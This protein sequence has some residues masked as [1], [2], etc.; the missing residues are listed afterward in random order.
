[1]V[2]V[3]RGATFG[4][5]LIGR[6]S[7]ID[8][9]GGGLEVRNVDAFLNVLRV[10]EK[11]FGIGLAEN[12]HSPHVKSSGITPDIT[13]RRVYELI[14]GADPSCKERAGKRCMP[15]T[16]RQHVCTPDIFA[17]LIFELLRH[18]SAGHR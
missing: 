8:G 7:R 17:K 9:P 6:T 13:V 15:M 10:R 14:A 11:S 18:A 12:R 3:D 2:P 5:E 1:M 4:A 16:R